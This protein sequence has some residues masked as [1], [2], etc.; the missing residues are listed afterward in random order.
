MIRSGVAAHDLAA[1]RARA[2][3]LTPVSRETSERLDRFVELLLR[4]QRTSNLIAPSTVSRL[5]TRHI[6]DSLQLIELAPQARV[7][8]DLGSGAGFPGLVL[9]IA[10]AGTPG[11]IVHLIESNTKKAAFLREA[12]RVTGASASVH[13]QRIEDFTASFQGAADIVTAR[14]VAPLKSLLAQCFPLLGKSGA[15]GLFAKGQHAELELEDAAAQMKSWNMH[16]TLAP[17]RTDPAG[18][19]VVIRL[20]RNPTPP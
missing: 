16:A 9:A 3:A 20:E 18:R 6:A 1:D 19:I 13:L 11:A 2:L 14:A 15:T 10:L 7:W 8:I 17:S 12:Q 4:W 5:W